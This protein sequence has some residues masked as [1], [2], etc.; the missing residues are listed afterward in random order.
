M[1]CT[2]PAASVLLLAAA[3]SAQGGWSPPVPEPALNSPAAD[4]GVQLSLDG[5]TLHFASFRSGNWE[6]WSATRAAVGAP[7]NAPQHEA[8]LGDTAVDDQP[9]LTASG[10]EI[11][12]SSTRAGGAGSSDIM[13]ATR[14]TPQSP[15]ST[16]TFVTEVNSASAESAPS[17]TA[18]GLEL[19]FYSTGWGNPSGNNNSLFVA[20]RASTALPFG[21]PQLV[22]EFSNA[23]TH[24]DCDIAPDGLSI[25]FTEYVAPRLEVMFAERA[26]RASPWA[27]AVVWPEFSTVG[28]SQGVYSFTRSVGTDEAFLSA[29]F[30]TTAGG[31][32]ILRTTRV[33]ALALPYGTG[34]GG[35]G[36]SVP[37]SATVGLPRL[38]NAAFAFTVAN[39]LPSAAAVLVAGFAADN[40]TVGACTVLVA[41]PWVTSPV[42]VLDA[43]GQGQAPLAI[44]AA[45]AL[46]GF[47]VYG[48]WLVIDPAGQFL[49]FAALSNGVVATVGY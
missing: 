16:P 40:V 23:N 27:P 12:F 21:T 39:A 41:T 5:L 35:T 42:V 28:T 49:G 36:A 13:R 14:V 8:A 38:G 29:G 33:P 1:R 48:Q 2:R 30:P 11:W 22:A 37:G 17:L 9:W 34:C 31:Q 44:P 26:T 3:V 15:W 32:E 47:A 10:L 46:A 24:R 20:T 4:T 6:L 19:F 25:V 43:A 18:D 7:W 45:P